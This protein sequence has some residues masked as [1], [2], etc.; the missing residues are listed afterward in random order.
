MLRPLR[1]CSWPGCANLTATPG[2]CTFHA[3][4]GQTQRYAGGWKAFAAAW[5]AAHPYCAHC[6]R[7]RARQVH[8]KISP[9]V[10]PSLRT[11]P[12]NVVGLCHTCHARQHA[13]TRVTTGQDRRRSR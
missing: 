11:D 8:H 10:A 3:N 5:L 1:P 9:R 4:H 12:A 6:R 13:P 7:A 2:G